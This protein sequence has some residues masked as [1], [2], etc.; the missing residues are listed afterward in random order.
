MNES[1][2]SDFVMVALVATV[3]TQEVQIALDPMAFHVSPVSMS[4]A[5]HKITVGARFD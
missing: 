2:N 4:L 1:I 5:S 3:P